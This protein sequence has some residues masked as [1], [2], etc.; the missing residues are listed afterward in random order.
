MTQ[1]KAFRQEWNGKWFININEI[2]LARTRTSFQTNKKIK[3]K[4]VCTYGAVTYPAPYYGHQWS[5]VMYGE[6]DLY[7]THINIPWFVKTPKYYY[8]SI[9]MVFDGTEEKWKLCA[10]GQAVF[11]YIKEQ[12]PEVGKGNLLTSPYLVTTSHIWHYKLLYFKVSLN[13][14]NTNQSL[15]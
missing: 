7:H 4:Y 9:R 11:L 10:F 3:D 6:A 1:A 8:Y 15:G 2:L 5:Q 12:H 14:Q 13:N